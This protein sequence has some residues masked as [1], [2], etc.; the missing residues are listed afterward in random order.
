[1]KKKPDNVV[2][3]DENKRYNSN[4][5]PYGSNVGAPSIKPTDISHWKNKNLTNFN[6]FLETR[7][8]EIKK[9]YEKL[10]ELYEWNKMIYE[11]DFGFQPIVGETYYL[12]QRDDS[13]Q[14]LSL[15]EPESWDEEHIGSFKFDSENKWIKVD[16]KKSPN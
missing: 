6:H 15:I 8:D 10:M 4:I 9:E 2:W 7:Y 5:L 11:S 12:Y 14:F 16:N 3:D 1:M 13:T